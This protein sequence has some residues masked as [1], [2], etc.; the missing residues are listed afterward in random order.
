MLIRKFDKNDMSRLICWAG[1]GQKVVE[2]MS[3]TMGDGD[4]M[5]KAQRLLKKFEQSANPLFEDERQARVDRVVY[6]A[7]YRDEVPA[8]QVHRQGPLGVA[9]VKFIRD[10]NGDQAHISYVFEEDSDTAENRETVAN[11]SFESYTKSVVKRVL[12]L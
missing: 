4:Y 8:G 6:L 9:T 11:Q 10:E 7:L 1:E 5:C 3:A 2:T 12:A